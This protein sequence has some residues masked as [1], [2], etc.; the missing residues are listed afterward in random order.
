MFSCSESEQKQL[1]TWVSFQSAEQ[2]LMGQFSVSG[3]NQDH[4]SERASGAS[5]ACHTYRRVPDPSSNGHN[6]CT[7]GLVSSS[8]LPAYPPRRIERKAPQIRNVDKSHSGLR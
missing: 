2:P 5:T 8:P 1:N 4:C 6:C 3:N 7:L